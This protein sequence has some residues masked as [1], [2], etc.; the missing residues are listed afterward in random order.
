MVWLLDGMTN[1]KSKMAEDPQKT[2]C[3]LPFMHLSILPD[4][5]CKLCAMS[6]KNI[7][8]EGAPFTVPEHSV[9]EIWHSVY[10]RS[11]RHRM[12]NGVPVEDCAAC[13]HAEA[14]S[15]TSFRTASNARWMP[16]VGLSDKAVD[17][18]AL[19]AV[20]L[21]SDAPLSYQLMPGNTCQL[22]C[23]MCSPFFSSRIASDAVHS[24]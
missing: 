9:K 22:A 1:W 3:I 24:K 5:G 11:V 21:P 23:R 16:R 10:M 14:I 12:L 18:H 8:R 4:G 15:G 17:G 13:Y 6:S 7:E 20:A 19:A 2:M